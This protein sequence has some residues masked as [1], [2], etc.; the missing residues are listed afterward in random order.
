[1]AKL[2]IQKLNG[3]TTVDSYTGPTTVSGNYL[4]G[5]GGFTSQTI[6]TIQPT[7]KVGAADA[8]VGSIITQKGAHKFQVS[9]E[10]TVN[11]E[12]VTVGNEYRINSVGTTDWQSMGAG[13][14][15]NTNDVFTAMAVGAGTGTVQNV[16]TCTLVNLVTPTAAN[17]M[18][19][20]C[21]AANV[22]NANIA[23]IGANTADNRITAYLTWN[24]G[25]VVSGPQFKVGQ[26]INL[27][28]SN[29]TGNL[30]IT[31]INSTTNLT[32]T[33]DTTQTVPVGNLTGFTSTFQ[34]SKISNKY[35]WDFL[36]GGTAESSS[37]GG[38]TGSTNPN[39]YRYWFA[40]ATTT[41]VKVASA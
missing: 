29:V 20:V 14:N 3:S 4:G 15:A 18:S 34:A 5:V 26:T 39:R 38:F 24:A 33:T 32:V 40:E 10:N 12:S 6:A 2:K 31:T 41:F 16:A 11:D 28:N 8:T 21:T 22:S 1:M 7:V 9:D 37:T 19:I 17:T 13:A 36:N 30:T 25:D 27:L 35:V 23:N